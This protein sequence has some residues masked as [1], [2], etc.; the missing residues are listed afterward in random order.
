MGV[1]IL[2]VQTADLAQ[3]C[4]TNVTRTN[5]ATWPINYVYDV[6]RVVHVWDQRNTLGEMVQNCQHNLHPEQS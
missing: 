1:G 4:D 5:G 6:R 2:V 3:I